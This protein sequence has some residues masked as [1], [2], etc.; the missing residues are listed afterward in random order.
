VRVSVEV[1]WRLL[2]ARNGQIARL[3]FSTPAG[4]RPELLKGV[5]PDYPS[6]TAGDSMRVALAVSPEGK[7]EEIRILETTD[8]KWAEDVKR[9][10]A[11]WRF[12]AQPQRAE[13]VLELAIGNPRAPSPQH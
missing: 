9:D 5:M 10:I 8:T 7:M 13:G 11:S 4:T 6:S 1:N 12:Q 3:N 2:G